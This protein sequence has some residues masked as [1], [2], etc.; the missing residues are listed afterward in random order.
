MLAIAAVAVV[1]VLVKKGKISFG[2]KTE[3]S[4]G[5]DGEIRTEE[6]AEDATEDGEAPEQENQENG[7]ED[8]TDD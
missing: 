4:D 6:T 7:G 8:K 2:G 3:V 1:L 5:G